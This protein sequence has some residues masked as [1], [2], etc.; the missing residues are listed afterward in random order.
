MTPRPLTIAY[1]YTTF[2]KATETFMQREVIALRARGVDLRI[3]SLFGGGGA[4]AGVAITRFSM[5][6]LLELVWVIPNVAV[7]RWDVFGVILHGLLKR[8][9]PSWLNFWENMLGAGF[10]GLWYP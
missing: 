9:P 1:L 4:F 6:R 8:R 10:A 7:T 5:W 2:P 3:Y